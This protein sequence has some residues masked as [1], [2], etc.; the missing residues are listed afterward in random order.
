MISNKQFEEIKIKIEE[1]EGQVLDLTNNEEDNET[2]NLKEKIRK[3]SKVYYEDY[4]TVENGKEI[5]NKR[6]KLFWED[7]KGWPFTLKTKIQAKKLLKNHIVVCGEITK[8]FWFISNL[9]LNFLK[10]SK[11]Y[12]KIVILHPDY[13]KFTG[14]SLHDYEVNKRKEKLERFPDIY[15]VSGR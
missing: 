12:R 6:G 2:S 1:L 9:R 10:N 14:D 7:F 3:S 8:I 15:Y 4:I 11:L 13:L 5:E